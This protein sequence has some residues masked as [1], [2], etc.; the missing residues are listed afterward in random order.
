MTNVNAATLNGSTSA[1]FEETN[2]NTGV[3]STNGAF[4]GNADNLPLELKL[5]NARVFRDRT[6]F[7]DL[8]GPACFVSLFV[9]RAR[10]IEAKI[11]QNSRFWKSRKEQI[12]LFYR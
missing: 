9:S 1:G 3:N 6:R 12:S 5:N 2:G 11:V 10:K 7:L 4:L 8:M